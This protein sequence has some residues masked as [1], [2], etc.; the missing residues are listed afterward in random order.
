[1]R[2]EYHTWVG[3]DE[4]GP[5]KPNTL[6]GWNVFKMKGLEERYPMKDEHFDFI[7]SSDFVEMSLKEGV[8][9]Q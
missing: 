6:L 5:K 8:E 7:L 2:E 3:D 4:E 9:T 1:M